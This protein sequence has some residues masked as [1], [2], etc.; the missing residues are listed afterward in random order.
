MTC[1][2]FETFAFQSRTNTV[3]EQANAIIGEYAERGFLLTL[4]QLFYQFV[5]RGLIE[6]VCEEFR[7]PYFA[8]RGNTSDSEVFQ[9]GKQFEQHVAVGLVPVVLHL[10]DHDPSGLDMSRD[11]Q[12]R[13]SLFARHSIDL[14][15]LA[16]NLDQIELYQPPPNFAKDSDSR[17]AA[18]AKRFGDKSWELDALDPTVIANLIRNEVSGLIDA[19]A[20]DRAKAEEAANRTLLNTASANWALVEKFL[21]RCVNLPAKRNQMHPGQWLQDIEISTTRC[22]FER[23]PA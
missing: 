19:D 3:I 4:R 18:Y 16:L 23:G 10:G 13:L 22:P 20:W 17:F 12:A 9:A 2:K 15:R 8:C 14:R 5:A 6:A 7:V 11:N 21:W 1:E